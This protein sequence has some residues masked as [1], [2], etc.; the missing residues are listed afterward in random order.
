MN[1]GR[2]K[3]SSP[4]PGQ[5]PIIAITSNIYKVFDNS[6]EMNNT[7]FNIIRFIQELLDSILNNTFQIFMGDHSDHT[8]G[9]RHDHIGYKETSHG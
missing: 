7:V 9:L 8:G 4:A 2:T 1:L 5:N 3:L 6:G